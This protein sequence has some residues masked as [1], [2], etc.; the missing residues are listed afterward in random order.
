MKVKMHLHSD[1][2]NNL[3]QGEK[4]GLIG[5]ALNNFIYALYEVEFEVD[6]DKDGNTTI[7][8]VN[9]RELKE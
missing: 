7:L 1:K 2:E 4:I 8:K 9:G 5:N 3:Y 6:I